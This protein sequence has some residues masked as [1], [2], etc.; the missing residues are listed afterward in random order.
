M[1]SKTIPKNE[2]MEKKKSFEQINRINS[3]N[4]LNGWESIKEMEINFFYIFLIT[5]HTQVDWY[6]PARPVLSVFPGNT[7]TL[8]I[9]STLFF[10]FYNTRNTTT[11][12]DNGVYLSDTLK[13]L[14]EQKKNTI[15]SSRSI[16]FSIFNTQPCQWKPKNPLHSDHMHSATGKRLK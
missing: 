16:D 8:S 7:L 14:T 13:T 2:K 3:I 15:S 4:E 6:N 5:H 11:P 1:Q 10:L 12:I 9:D